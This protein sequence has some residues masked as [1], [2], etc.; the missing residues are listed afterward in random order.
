MLQTDTAGKER[1]PSQLTLD[2]GNKKNMVKY[3][4]SSQKAFLHKIY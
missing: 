4:F 1:F 2:L 3:S